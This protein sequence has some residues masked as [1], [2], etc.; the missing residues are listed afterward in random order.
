MADQ[1][2]VRKTIKNIQRVKTWQ[3]VIL[4][5]IF[6]LVAATFLRLNNVGMVERRTAVLQADESGDKI[7]L[8]N[9]LYALQRYV[10]EHMNADP[11]RIALQ[12]QYE[13]DAKIAKDKAQ[14]SASNKGSNA[15]QQA[16]SV[17][18]PQAVTQ[19]WRWP[20]PRYLNCINK[21]LKK[22]PASEVASIELPNVGLYYHTFYSPMWSPDFAGWS[23]VLCAVILLVIIIRLLSLVILKL[24]LKKHYSSV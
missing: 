2:Q 10:S 15:Y 23:L 16:S 6:G 13:R 21:E 22:Y 9:N 12:H 17:C 1:R 7:A 3:L 8:F 24:L 18:D 14:R 5:I 19:G 4:L 20:D 11:G